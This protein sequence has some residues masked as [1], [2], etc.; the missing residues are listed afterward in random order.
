[1]GPRKFIRNTA[2][3]IKRT[4]KKRYNIGKKK[5]GGINVGQIARDVAS[6]AKIINSE[7][8]I[9]DA[10][11]GNELVNGEV[12]GQLDF[13]STGI[14]TYDI[15]PGVPTGPNAGDR[16]GNSIKLTSSYYNMLIQAQTNLAVTAR[17]RIEMWKN[18]G[19]PIDPT[20][21]LSKLYN[22]NPFTQIIDYYS[23]RNAD[24]F[25]HFTKIY[26]KIITIPN[27]SLSGQ[28]YARQLQIPYSWGQ[29]HHIR[30]TSSSTATS[31]TGIE[32]GQFFLVLLMDSGNSN[33][34]TSTNA[35]ILGSCPVTTGLTGVVVRFAQRHYYYDN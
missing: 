3:A 10:G 5:K 2:R 17:F 11:T 32:T 16:N 14:R 13:N 21:L 8:K 9:W 30:Y 29:G 35:T 24:H 6:M 18:P 25:S 12:V 7:K 28:V 34:V 1:M 4:V 27:D 23:S 19:I 20:T 26:N 31:Y 33:A 15:T 22:V